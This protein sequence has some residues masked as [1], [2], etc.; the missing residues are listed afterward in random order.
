VDRLLYMKVEPMGDSLRS[1]PRFDKL[2]AKI[3]LK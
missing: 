1:D 2:L 3:G